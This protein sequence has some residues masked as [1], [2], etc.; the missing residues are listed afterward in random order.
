MH[1]YGVAVA[2]EGEVDFDPVR[3][4]LERF[5]NSEQGVFRIACAETAV[6]LN[7]YPQPRLFQTRELDAFD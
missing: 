2:R 7:N 6:G 3:A 1:E 5:F 4:D